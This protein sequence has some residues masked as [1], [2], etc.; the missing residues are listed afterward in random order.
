[1]TATVMGSFTVDRR[2][3][4]SPGM[5]GDTMV[6]VASPVA[7]PLNAA[8]SERTYTYRA[9]KPDQGHSRSL[10]SKRTSRNLPPSFVA[11]KSGSPSNVPAGEVAVRH[12]LLPP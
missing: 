6:K 2:S 11:V 4:V 9:R 1:M 3:S 5:G 7:V 8:P 10:C 12:T